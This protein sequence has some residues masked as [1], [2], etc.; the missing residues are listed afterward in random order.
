MKKARNSGLF[1]AHA[2]NYFVVAFLALRAFLAFLAGA[3]CFFTSLA[4]AGAAAGAAWVAGA[5]GAAGAAA[6]ANAPMDR[7][8]ATRAA[9]SLF[10]SNFPK[11]IYAVTGADY[12]AT[13]NVPF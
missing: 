6:W 7:K 9:R 4:A 12:P 3:L 13:Q 2:E 11:N 8:P 1:K 10:I 5:T